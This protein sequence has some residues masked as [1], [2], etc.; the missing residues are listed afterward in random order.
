M[1]LFE[2]HNLAAERGESVVFTDLSFCLRPG[3]LLHVRGANGS[4]KTTLL[5]TLVGLLP[6]HQGKIHWCGQ[7]ISRLGAAY[8]KV[9]AYLG[10]QNG[11]RPYLSAAEN[12]EFEIALHGQQS[13]SREQALTATGLAAM[14]DTPARYLSA[15][16]RQR[17]ALAGLLLSPARLWILD[18]P[19]TSLDTGALAWFETRLDQHLSCGGMV[20][21]TSHHPPTCAVSIQKLDML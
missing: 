19:F 4:G 11:V 7:A 9:V 20:V 1:P 3:E 5:R 15:G 12:L 18:E 2:V 10:H 14:A 6:C 21:M 13:M 16:E 17:L 8:Q